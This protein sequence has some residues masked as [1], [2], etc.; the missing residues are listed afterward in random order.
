MKQRILLFALFSLLLSGCAQKTDVVFPEPS[1]NQQL[2]F[3]ADHYSHPEFKTEWW[4]YTGHLNDAQGREYGFELVFFRRRTD[5][6]V[7]HGIPVRLFGEQVYLSHFAITDIGAGQHE[8]KERFGVEK[9]NHA[10]ARDDR[11]KVWIDDWQVQ[12]IAGTHHLTAD[13]DGYAVDLLMSPEKP[14]IV[15]GEDGISRKGVG[16]ASSYYISFTRLKADGFLYLAGEP[17]QVSGDAWSDH[18][19]FGSGLSE[20]IQGWDWFSI[21]LDDDTELMLFHLNRQDGS[22]DQQ[23]AGTYVRADG[24]Y[25]SFLLEDFSIEALSHWTSPRTKAGYP[26]VWRIRVPKYDIELD[27]QTSLPDQELNAKLTQVAYYE[28]SIKARGRVGDRPVTGRGYVEMSGY[29]E[30]VTGL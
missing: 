19:I 5:V 30:P 21:Q 6:E 13:M 11:Y 18:E 24:S 2:V 1:A 10:G 26:A 8:F 14:P 28:G 4:Y 20:Q 16:S 3:P 17:V 12:D 29:T 23:S 9:N 22:I 27:V 7:R 15:H 25:D